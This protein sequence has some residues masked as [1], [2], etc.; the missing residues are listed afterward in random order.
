MPTEERGSIGQVRPSGW[1]LVKYDCV[2]GKYLF[3]RCHLIG[4]QLAGENANICNL[5]TG[6]R[7]LNVS[8]M[9]PFEEKV[10]TYVESTGNH[11][12]FRVMP[13]FEGDELVA[14][15]VH[16]EA[17]SVEDDGA[18]LSFNVYCYNVQPGIGID[19]VTGESWLAEEAPS[20][21]SAMPSVAEDQQDYVLNTNAKKFHYPDCSSV[22]DMKEK[23]KQIYSGTRSDLID[24]GYSPCSR[25]NP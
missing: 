24:Q 11:V 4:Y 15:G 7:Y 5:I 18:G 20:D 8:G 16:M 23:N 3:N 13:V 1:H 22:S 25:C 14:R 6:T 9:L 2:D 21:D 19:Y 12:L 17:L 10:A